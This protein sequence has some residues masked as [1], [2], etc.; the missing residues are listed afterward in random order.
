MKITKGDVTFSGIALRKEGP[1][2]HHVAE[3]TTRMAKATVTRGGEVVER[4]YARMGTRNREAEPQQA[5]KSQ[6]LEHTRGMN[7]N[8]S[9]EHSQTKRR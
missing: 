3:C 6:N 7:R 1:F 8:D 2:K 4:A 5:V 9:S